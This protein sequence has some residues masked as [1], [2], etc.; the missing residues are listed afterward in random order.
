MM[1]EWMDGWTV[2][3]E[4][5]TNYKIDRK[6]DTVKRWQWTFGHDHTGLGHTNRLRWETDGHV[7]S[8]KHPSMDIFGN[9]WPNKYCICQFRDFFIF[10]I[11][12]DY[13]YIQRLTRLI[14]VS[15]RITYFDIYVCVSHIQTLKSIEFHPQP[16]AN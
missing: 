6:I 2:S 16:K 8:I 11:F 14:D 12:L 9:T 13:L 3:A 1:N 15:T 4:T 10:S 7:N 5:P